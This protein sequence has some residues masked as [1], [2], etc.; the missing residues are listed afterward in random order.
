MFLGTKYV[1][2]PVF[3]EKYVLQ[4]MDMQKNGSTPCFSPFSGYHREA[5][6]GC[7]ASHNIIYDNFINE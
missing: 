2:I 3:K 6:S 1:S 7:N 4:D 5:C